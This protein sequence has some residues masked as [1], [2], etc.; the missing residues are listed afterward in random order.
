M[1]EDWGARGGGRAVHDCG[2]GI[3]QAV[4]SGS[5]GST[6]VVS[7]DGCRHDAAPCCP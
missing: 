7:S 2:V 5:D 1:E 4:G 3:G 6:H